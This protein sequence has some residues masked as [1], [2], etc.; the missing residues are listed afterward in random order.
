MNFIHHKGLGNHLLQLCPKVVKHSVYY[1]KKNANKYN[2][3]IE[4]TNTFT[5]VGCFLAY[6]NEKYITVAMS[7]FPP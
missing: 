6:L 1:H 4:Q 2:D 5:N 7:K 3:I